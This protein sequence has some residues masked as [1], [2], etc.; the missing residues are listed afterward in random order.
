MAKTLKD[1]MYKRAAMSLGKK[2]G[3][4]DPKAKAAKPAKNQGYVDIKNKTIEDNPRAIG[5][6]TVPEIQEY[7]KNV[8][9]PKQ[10]QWNKMLNE[11]KLTKAQVSDSM[12][13]YKPDKIDL[14]QLPKPTKYKKKSKV[15][16]G[17]GSNPMW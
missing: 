2:G 14:K 9:Q 3:G 15:K 4:D 12:Q 8:Y 5:G 11:G 16:I 1:H 17:W 13:Y 10:K 7:D 6:L